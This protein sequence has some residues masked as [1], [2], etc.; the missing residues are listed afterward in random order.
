MITIERTADL[1]RMTPVEMLSGVAFADESGGHKFIVTGMR[2]GQPEAFTGTVS[3]QVVSP[4]GETV[5]ITSAGIEDGKA[6]AVLPAACYD[7]KGYF[8]VVIG[9]SSGGGYTVIYACTG[10]MTEV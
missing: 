4:G 1:D 9:I 10:Y 6:W 3:G 8:N 7:G 5:A 2:N